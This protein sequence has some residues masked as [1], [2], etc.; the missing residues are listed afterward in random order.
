M[1]R[2]RAVVARQAHNLKA[3]GSIPS[4]ATQEKLRLYK[5]SFFLLYTLI[6]NAIPSVGQ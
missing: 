2:S 5:R 1:A 6:A 3:G 4:S